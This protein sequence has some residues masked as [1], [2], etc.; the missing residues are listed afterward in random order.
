MIFDI[1]PINNKHISVRELLETNNWTPIHLAHC[2]LAMTLLNRIFSTHRP[3]LLYNLIKDSIR[4]DSGEVFRR[5]FYDS[6][7]DLSFEHRHD[8]ISLVTP[9][10]LVHMEKKLFPYSFKEDFNNLPSEIRK[11]FATE[12]FPLAI[13]LYYGYSCH[14]KI[15]NSNCS[16]CKNKNLIE[17]NEE[18]HK[19]IDLL[20]CES[21]LQDIYFMESEDHLKLFYQELEVAMHKDVCINLDDIRRTDIM[22]EFIT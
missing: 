16:R 8:N 1:H 3:P 22:N 17:N 11:T 5:S 13:N 12:K 9:S 21:P 20:L 14:H 15:L 6:E 2:K 10:H 19:R 4:Y 7:I 18:L